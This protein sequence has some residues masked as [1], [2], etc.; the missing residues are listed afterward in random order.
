MWQCK[1]KA[2]RSPITRRDGTRVWLSIRHSTFHEHDNKRIRH[3]LTQRCLRNDR[4]ASNNSIIQGI[5]QQSCQQPLLQ[6]SSVDYLMFNWLFI[7]V[8][9]VTPE[10][11]RPVQFYKTYHTEISRH[12]HNVC[13]PRLH[14]CT[15][16]EASFPSRFPQ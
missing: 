10:R 14:F 1:N 11:E 7:G 16:Y 13:L 5:I 15:L 4:H 6:W 2:R 12:F 8:T 9:M 3:L